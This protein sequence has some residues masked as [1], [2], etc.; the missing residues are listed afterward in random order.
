MVVCVYLVTSYADMYPVRLSYSYFGQ[1]C[2]FSTSTNPE[3]PQLKIRKES[4][5]KVGRKFAET[6]V[7]DFIIQLS[8]TLI[9]CLDCAFKIVI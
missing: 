4:K 2:C 3:R 1:K 8:T 9:V 5:F 6:S 7:I